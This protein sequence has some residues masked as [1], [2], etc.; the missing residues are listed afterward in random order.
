MTLLAGFIWQLTPFPAVIAIQ[1][2]S[3]PSKLAS[4]GHRGANP[5][6]NKI[7]YWLDDARRHYLAPETALS[8]ALWMGYSKPRA[9]LTQETL[10]RNLKIADSLGLLTNEN[11]DRL[12]H[13]RAAIITIGPY[14][15]EAVEIDHIVPISLAPELG[16]ELANLEMLPQTLNRQKS[17]RVGERQLT[18]AER[19]RAAGLLKNESYARLRQN[20]QG[21]K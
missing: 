11:R 19:F 18:F 15:G 1:S 9:A 12:R 8:M 2:L 17:N 13:G 6:L 7:V 14:R 3:N 10:L 21:G 16:N 4:L 5:R 20:G